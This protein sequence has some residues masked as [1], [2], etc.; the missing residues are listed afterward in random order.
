MAEESSSY[1]MKSF[2]ENVQTGK[3]TES[4]L[5]PGKG[6]GSM[7]VIPRQ[8]EISLWD[9]NN[10]LELDSGDIGI[11]FEYMSNHCNV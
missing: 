7:G 9:N 10:I 4:R 1:G 2:K 11:I 3:S 8:D 6:Q 5:V